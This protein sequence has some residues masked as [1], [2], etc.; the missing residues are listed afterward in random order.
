MDRD[1]RVWLGFLRSLVIYNNPLRTVPLRRFYRRLLAPG[2]LAFDVGAHVGT[3]ARA[4]RAAGAR[5]VAVEPQ[6][7]F[8]TFLRRSL[9]RDITLV[10]AALGPQE[11]VA[12]MAVSS[13][14]PTV[15]SLQPG[16]ADAA[17][18]A[19]GFGHVRWDRRQ[20]VRV[21]TLDALIDRHGLPAYVKIDVEGFELS[22]LSGLSRPVPLVSVEYLPALPDATHRVIARLMEIGPYRFNPVR[23]EDGHFLWPDWRDAD[24]ARAWLAG[25]P[26]GERSGDLYARLASG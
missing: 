15:S 6:A 26:R 24:A 21:T 3:R 19:P 23:G 16:F 13:L 1:M 8:S 5:V 20:Q 12:E 11:T 25:L 2:D 4:M 22:V 14:H 17:L 9:P 7:P 18:S 10:E